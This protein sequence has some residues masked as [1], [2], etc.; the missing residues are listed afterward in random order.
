MGNEEDFQQNKEQEDINDSN[1]NSFYKKLVKTLK[2]QKN[3]KL[4][5]GFN[6]KLKRP[7]IK[8]GIIAA[9]IGRGKSTL[10][11]VLFSENN[12]LGNSNLNEFPTLT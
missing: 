9:T 6:K 8:I 2:E 10:I 4:N 7:K 5:N 12:S 3:K 1:E 11:N